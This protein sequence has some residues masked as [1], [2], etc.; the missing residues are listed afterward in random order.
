ML[1]ILPVIL[2]GAADPVR[3][4][5]R[6]G[7]SVDALLKVYAKCIDGQEQEMNARILKG[8]GRR[9]RPK[10][11]GVTHPSRGSPGETRGFRVATARQ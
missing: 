1:L 11:D 4:A 5:V 3:L 2:P 8:L 6:A 10:A 9:A 7:H